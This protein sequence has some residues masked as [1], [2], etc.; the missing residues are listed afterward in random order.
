MCMHLVARHRISQSV[1][2]TWSIPRCVSS[3]IWLMLWTHRFLGIQTLDDVVG[4][5]TPFTRRMAI[6]A[7]AYAILKIENE[8][9]TGAWGDAHRHSVEFQSTTHFPGDDVIRARGVAADAQAAN[10]FAFGVVERETAA[11]Y[12][13]T[14]DSFTE[15]G[16]R[17]LAELLGIAGECDGWIRRANDSGEWATG[18]CSSVNVAGGQREIICAEG[19]RSVGF[20]GGYNAAA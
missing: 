7:G 6:A 13:H 3:Q 17:L 12:N 11:E 16:I 1:V 18:L 19:V 10:Q 2:D 8:V 4:W 5:L 15:H 9:V 20:F 14:A